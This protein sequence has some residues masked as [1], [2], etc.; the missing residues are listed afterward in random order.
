MTVAELIQ[1]IVAA[2]SSVA[3]AVAILPLALGG[4]AY[5]LREAGNRV[6]SQRVANLNIGLGLFAVLVIILW[7]MY[8]SGVKGMLGSTNVLVFIGPLYWV[9]VGFVAE[10]QLH[11]GEQ[12]QIRKRVR[13]VLLFIAILGVLYFVLSRLDMHM[14][15]WT[16]VLGFVFFILALIGILYAL[17][18]KVV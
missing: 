16:N 10:H 17:I 7:T 6:G 3:L 14:V 1:S 18:R 5:L 2:G 4:V 15:I 12:R 8:A 13:S 9:G 11:P